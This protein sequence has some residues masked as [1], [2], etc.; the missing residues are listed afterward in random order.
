MAIAMRL[1]RRQHTPPTPQSENTRP[2][3]LGA[4]LTFGLLAITTR[5]FYWQVLSGSHLQAAAQEQYERSITLSGKRGLIFSADGSPLVANQQVYRVFVQPQVLN[6]SPE[7]ITGMILD[8]LLAENLEY[9][10]ASESAKKEEIKAAYKQSLL[11]KLSQKDSKWVNLKNQVSESTKQAIEELEIHG[12]GFDPYLVR[13]YPEASMAAHALG[14]V[15]KDDV[16]IDTGYFGVEGALQKELEGRSSTQT[17]FTDARGFQLAT[18]SES[19]F[20]LKDGRSVTLTLR[21]DV[22]HLLETKLQAALQRYGA[23]SGEVIVL[24]PRTGAI[25]GM[26]SLPSYDPAHFTQFES[27]LYKNPSLASVYEPGSTFKVLTVAAGIQE[28]IINPDTQCTKC[29]GPRVFGKYTIRTWNDEYHPNITMTDALAKSDNTAMIFVA[30]QLGADRFSDYLKKFGIGQQLGVELQEDT[31][32]PFPDKWGPVELA[33]TSFG[34]GVSTNSLQIL[35]A[36]AAIANGG[37]LLR[38]TIVQSVTDPATG[39]IL[40]QQPK[41]IRQVVSPATAQTV[42]TMMIAAAEHGEAQWIASKTHNVAGK[43][44]TSQIAENGAYLDDK[45]IAS[46]VG[47]APADNPQFAM[48]VKLTAPTSSIWAAET[49]APLWYAIADRLYLLLNIPPDK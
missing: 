37:M 3:I 47:F 17:I 26:A 12:L 15:G 13:A 31:T 29:D 30:E 44:G 2:R 34:Q 46:F 41:E 45:T 11:S 18:G 25:L 6:Q 14:F 24:N 36:I 42:T 40:V 4:L 1:L 39:E 27:Q 20:G 5:L 49:A 43:T 9:Q 48:I 38:P 28:G 8:P 23:A 35:N 21:R 7:S 22:Q 16:G 19:E 33:T 32:T 10:E